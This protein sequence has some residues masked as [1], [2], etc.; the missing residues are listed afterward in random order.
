L[1][2]DDI[3]IL[4]EFTDSESAATRLILFDRLTLKKKWIIDLPGFNASIPLIYMESIYIS[5]MGTVGKFRISDGGMLWKHDDIGNND[6][7]GFNAFLTPELKSKK[8]YFTEDPRMI[9]PTCKRRTVVCDD[10]SGKIAKI[11]AEK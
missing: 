8:I 5:V 7:C 11:Y 6:S 1:I 9:N 3:L 10:I 2:N 4:Y